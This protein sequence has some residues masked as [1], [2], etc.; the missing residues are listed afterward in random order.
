MKNGAARV[1]TAKGGDEG[2][3]KIADYNLEIAA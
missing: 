2:G 3:G 1:R